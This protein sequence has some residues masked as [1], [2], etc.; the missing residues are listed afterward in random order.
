MRPLR[1]L[2]LAT[3]SVPQFVLMNA[4]GAGN[5]NAQSEI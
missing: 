1:G 2:P 4:Y 3:L 5:S